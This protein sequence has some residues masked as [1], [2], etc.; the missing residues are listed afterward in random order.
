MKRLRAPNMVGRC[1]TGRAIGRRSREMVRTCV[2]F[3]AVIDRAE[4][5]P[6]S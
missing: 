3:E 5:T 1:W 4:D 6:R 2:E